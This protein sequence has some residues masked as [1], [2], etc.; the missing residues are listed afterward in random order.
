MS[1]QAFYETL[2]RPDLAEL[3]AER[4]LRRDLLIYGGLLFEVGG[5]L[6]FFYSV[7]QDD[8]LTLRGWVGLGAF[9]VGFA[10][11]TAGA[12]MD[13]TPITEQEAAALT[14][15]YNAAL[16]RRLGL[17]SASNGRPTS[18]WSAAPATHVPRAFTFKLGPTLI[19]HGSAL[20]ARVDF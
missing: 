17:P 8:G 20:V 14:E 4:T 2:G 12:S 15:R 5:A 11:S 16:R 6:L 7:F 9:A 19:R 18:L 3:H 10:T 13:L 1:Y